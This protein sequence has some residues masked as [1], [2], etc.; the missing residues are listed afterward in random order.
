MIERAIS[1]HKEGKLK[2][3]SEVYQEILKHSPR[4]FDAL[5]FCGLLYAQVQQWERALELLARALKVNENSPSILNNL[6]I[7]FKELKKFDEAI[8]S[9]EKAVVLNPNYAEA[10]NNLGIVFQ[11]QGKLEEALNRYE[12]AIALKVDYVEAY[13]N[14]GNVLSQ[15]KNYE[16]AILSCDKA[17]ELK[18]DYAQAYFN[19]GIALKGLNRYQ[20]AHLN[21]EQAISLNAHYVEAYFNNAILFQDARE[22]DAAV[23]NYQKAIELRADYSQAH[24]NLGAVLILQNKLDEA[25]VSFSKVIEINQTHAETHLNCGNIYKEFKLFSKALSSYSKAIELKQ[26]YAE[27]YGNRGSI[28]HEEG[29]FDKAIKDYKKALSLNPLLTK[30]TFSLSSLGVGSTPTT[31]PTQ[32]LIELFD[33]YANKFDDH[34]TGLLGYQA[35][36]ILM[37]QFKR[38]QNYKIHQMLD[39]GCGTGLC[40]ESFV[41]HAQLITG[42]DISEKMLE[43]AKAKKI[44]S[45]LICTDIVDFL[46]NTTEKYDLVVSADVFI[47]MGELDHI[48]KDV[49]STL[50]INGLFSFTIESSNAQRFELKST[51]R[52]GHSQ[53]YILELASINGFSVLEI[54]EVQLRKEKDVFISGA[55][56][57]MQYA[58]VSQALKLK[59]F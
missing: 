41:A 43:Q 53:S 2:E 1:L 14:R 39:L 24:F 40:G 7:V 27:A 59:D 28:Y 17:I 9:F 3:A 15:L 38:H 35:P 42:V 21:Y 33:G 51:Q 48:I 52:Y 57:L 26:D 44:Y 31:M 49:A 11:E 55:A 22:L 34:L 23:L 32:P 54:Q 37:N 56:I 36:Q 8:S 16:Q 50:K 6:G 29:E 20:E 12:T 30:I 47:Y 46:K 5:H 4:H 10:Y 19:K 45:K 58:G 18:N 13:G 25:L